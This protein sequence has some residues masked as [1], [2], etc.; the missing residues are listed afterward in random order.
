VP[1]GTVAVPGT[2]LSVAVGLGARVAVPVGTGGG[3]AVQVNVCVAAA[4]TAGEG[5]LT[6]AAAGEQAASIKPATISV[7]NVCQIMPLF[8][9]LTNYLF[10]GV[11]VGAGVAGAPGVG[12]AVVPKLLSHG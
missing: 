5:L 4:T 6:E 8:R 1:A 7:L 11:A 9:P 2:R 10:F 12:V 3:V